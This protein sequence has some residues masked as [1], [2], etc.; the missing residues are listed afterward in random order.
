MRVTGPA[1][2]AGASIKM[3]AVETYGWRCAECGGYG[4]AH[5]PPGFVYREDGES[6][7]D[8]PALPGGAT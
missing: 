6:G 2:L 1:V 3:S 4:N 5:L 8:G 7:T